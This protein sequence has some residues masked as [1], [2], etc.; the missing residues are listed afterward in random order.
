VC[1]AIAQ[2]RL[3]LFSY[4]GRARLA[5][6]C[7]HGFLSTGNE[8]LRAHEVTVAGGVRRVGMGKLFRLDT[9]RD[10]RISDEPFTTPPRGYR[11]DD[12]GMAGIHCQL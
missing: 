4:S 6:P 5:Y 2:R 12:R 7:A 9:M 8:A 10:V 1:T 3:L 11:R